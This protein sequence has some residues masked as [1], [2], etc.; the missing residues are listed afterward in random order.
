MILR[1]AASL[2]VLAACTEH[3]QLAKDPLD[4][5]VSLAI[6]PADT[7]I[8]ITDLSQPPQSL[9]YRAM[10]KFLDGTKHD[11]TDLVSW[12]VDN[13]YPGDFAGPGDYE[14]SNQAA[15][16]VIIHADGDTLA[17]TAK[18]DV[19]ITTTVVDA[20]FPPPAPDL[21]VPGTPVVTDDPTHSPALVYPTDGTMFPQGVASTLF[22]Y[23][24][25]S[26]NDTFQLAFDCDVLHLA[27]IT[28]ADRW[29]ASGS[30]Q[31]VIAQSCIGARVAITLE[32]ASAAAGTIYGAA[33]AA[34]AFS[35]DRP[36]G[37]IYYWSA[38]TTGI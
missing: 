8:L 22:Q 38:A 9:Q 2:A 21:F 10:G 14:T 7:T 19:V 20:A 31:A 30:T 27:V 1:A 12:K 25:G 18:L 23:T 15:G 37:I 13:S 4:G 5:L 32:G 36:D 16:H 26:G 17:A 29:L 34:I 3:V 28:G 11:V 24:A 6:T 33:P 35:D